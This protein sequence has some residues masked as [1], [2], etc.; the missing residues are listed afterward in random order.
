[1]L[2]CWGMENVEGVAHI[3]AGWDGAGAVGI[4]VQH[5]ATPLLAANNQCHVAPPPESVI[6]S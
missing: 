1:M 3:Y 6:P 2:L 5:F 4:A